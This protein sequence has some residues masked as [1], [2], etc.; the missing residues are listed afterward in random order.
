MLVV[1][2][3]ATSTMSPETDNLGAEGGKDRQIHEETQKVN[4]VVGDDEPERAAGSSAK[5]ASTDEPPKH[6]Y[7][8]THPRSAS[9]LLVQILNLD[10]QHHVVTGREDAGYYFKPLL[11]TMRFHIWERG[12]D[13]WTPEELTNFRTVADECYA[14]LEEDI[15]KVDSEPGKTS[16]F[17]KEH[18][19]FFWS[20]FDYIKSSQLSSSPLPKDISDPSSD[21]SGTK[22]EPWILDGGVKSEANGTFLSDDFFSRWMPTFLVRHPALAIPSRVRAAKELGWTKHENIEDDPQ[23]AMRC[24]LSSSRT[25]YDLF[26]ENLPQKSKQYGG[27]DW[28]V[29]LTGDV[30]MTEPEVIKR[31]AS[32]VRLDANKLRFQ[33]DPRP[34]EVVE[35]MMKENARMLST[36]IASS[37]IDK[38]KTSEAVDID[39][40]VLK[41]RK[42]FGDRTAS[43]LE[44]WVRAAMPDYEFFEARRLRAEPM[45]INGRRV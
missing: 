30:V 41:W 15:G 37:G 20:P 34:K 39:V 33:W 18:C 9:N 44:E 38:S 45:L 1:V 12:I 23:I 19:E 16:M 29:V 27:V 5:A 7:L 14:N 43:K 21:R 6:F 10:E 32:L 35:K 24:S 17:V 26:D 8:L 4:G 36:L 42:E 31:Y 25:L 40:E 3:K 28:P 2:S 11:R 22:A 13:T